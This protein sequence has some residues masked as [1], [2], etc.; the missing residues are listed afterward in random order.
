MPHRNH[1]SG[2][3][4]SA[5]GAGQPGAA[6]PHSQADAVPALDGGA[7]D[8]DALGEQRIGF[9]NGADLIERDRVAIRDETD[10]VRVA[11]IDRAGVVHPLP[12]DRHRTS[13]HRIG[14]RDRIPFETRP[15]HIDARAGPVRFDGDDPASGFD[16]RSAAVEQGYRARSIAAG[17]DFA[18]IPVKNSHVEIGIGARFEQHELVATDPFAAVRDRRGG[19][20]CDRR[21]GIGAR[22]EHD[23]IIA[24]AVHLDEGNAHVCAHLCR[25]AANFQP[26]PCQTARFPRIGRGRRSAVLVSAADSKPLLWSRV[27][28]SP[29]G[30]GRP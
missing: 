23:E 12:A 24:E 15:A 28:T 11:D 17:S 29:A 7:I 14:E 30:S 10:D 20:R 22:I 19:S 9:D 8:V 13:V 4:A 2:A 3:G 26:G 16:S 6:F 25:G 1:C 5:A 21:Q 18:A 27:S